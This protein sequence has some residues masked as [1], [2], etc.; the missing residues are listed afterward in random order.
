M[1]PH[2]TTRVLL[3]LGRCEENCGRGWKV[4]S[5]RTAQITKMLSRVDQGLEHISAIALNAADRSIL[6]EP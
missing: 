1:S 6:A 5:R 4:V 2:T 3:L